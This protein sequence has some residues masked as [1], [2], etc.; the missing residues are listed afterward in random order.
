[1]A[2]GIKYIT[3][4]LLKDFVQYS[5][6][7]TKNEH[8]FC[9]LQDL[10]SVAKSQLP[11]GLA[12]VQV[13]QLYLFGQKAIGSKADLPP[14]P[15]FNLI[16]RL[17]FFTISKQK[18]SN[19]FYYYFIDWAIKQGDNENTW[20]FRKFQILKDPSNKTISWNLLQCKISIIPNSQVAYIS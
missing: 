13:C 15:H 14:L 2:G 12:D 4:S 20:Y 19:L 8:F 18:Y 5:P 17:L 3:W 7:S 16:Y 10:R 9:P 11:A 6:F 1:M